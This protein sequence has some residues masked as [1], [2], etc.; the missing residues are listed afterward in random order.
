MAT[1]ST[2]VLA[3][4]ERPQ[5]P[6]SRLSTLRASAR[7]STRSA[8]SPAKP[9]RATSAANATETP[10][11]PFSQSVSDLQIVVVSNAAEVRRNVKRIFNFSALLYIFLL[12]VLNLGAIIFVQVAQSANPDD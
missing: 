11:L 1:R 8:V 3:A 4:A 10:V 9:A 6:P 12:V 2:A 7:F 5:R